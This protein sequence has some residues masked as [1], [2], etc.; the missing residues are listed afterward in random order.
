MTRRE[1]AAQ[2]AARAERERAAARRLEA[3]RLQRE[4]ALGWGS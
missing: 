3:A 1:Q 2:H 4:A